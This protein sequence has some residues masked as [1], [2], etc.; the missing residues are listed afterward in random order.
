MIVQ[1][2]KVGIISPFVIA[3]SPV[4]YITGFFASTT[5]AD[6]FDVIFAHVSFSLLNIR[7]CAILFA[8][9]QLNHNEF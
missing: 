2:S 8:I 9:L 5:M 1:R 6:K 3:V 4:R 7:H